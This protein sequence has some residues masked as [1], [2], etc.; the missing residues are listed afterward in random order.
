MIRESATPGPLG[1]GE[2]M[3]LGAEAM[4]VSGPVAL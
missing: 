1:V 4:P 2:Q 3:S